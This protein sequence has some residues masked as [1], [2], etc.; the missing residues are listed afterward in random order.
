MNKR[1]I[2][3][4]LLSLICLNTKAQQIKGVVTDS[5]SVPIVNANISILNS[6]K[7]LGSITDSNGAYSI[8]V[9]ANVKLKIRFSYIGYQSV[10]TVV[11][12]KK[13]QTKTLNIVLKKDIISLQ[14]IEIKDKA[15]ERD[16]LTHIDKQW[17]QNAV[18]VDKQ[19]ENVIKSQE[20]VSSNNELSSQY[21]VRGGNFDENLVYV[22]DIEIFRPLLIRNGQQ[23]GLS[24][25]N[26]D[27]ISDIKFSSGGFD[28]KY[29]DKLSSVLDIRYSKP[30]EFKGSANMSL[31]GAAVHLEGLIGKRF[32]YTIG[33]RNKSSKYILNSLETSGD[34]N[35][36]FNDLQMYLT[37]SLNS[38]LELSFLGN[39]SDNKYNF[40][41]E[42]RQTQFG[43]IYTTMNL[44]IYFDGQ[45]QDRF[46]TGFGALM[47]NYSPKSDLNLKLI[48][49]GF[50][51]LEKETY[52]IQGQYWL[53]ETGGLGSDQEFDRG[54]GTYLEHARNR[55]HSQIYNIEHK[56][57]KDYSKGY[58]SWGVK[59]QREDIF[60]KLR[61]W[62]LVD[63]S[64]YTIPSCPDQIG[65]Y[66]P[67][68]PPNVQDYYKSKNSITTNR[69]TAYIQRQFVFEKKHGSYYFNIGIR[70]MYWD[71]N[72]EIMP[73]P[74]TSI[75]FRPNSKT[76]IVF[77]FA[78]GLYAQSPFYREMRD[79]SGNINYDIKSQKSW[80]FVLSEDWT[81]RML[82]RNFKFITTAY[83]KYLWDL[84]P[85]Q[86]DNVRIRYSGKNNAKGYATGMDFKLFGEFVQGIDSWITL[87]FLQTKQDIKGD[88][89]GYLPRPTDQLFNVSVSF[90]DYMP[91][92]PWMKVYLNFNYGSGYP[93]YKKDMDSYQRMPA[94]LRADMAFTFR[95]KDE[96]SSWAKGNF[97]TFFKRIWLNF[98]WLN[99]FN[100]N[101]VISYTNVQDFNGTIF[102]VPDYLT[103]SRLNVRLS[104]EF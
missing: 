15:T 11:I 63:S 71:F 14:E 74:R 84:I 34:Y 13:R 70:G 98:E 92:M 87:S 85:Y 78:T 37:Y 94:Y 3:I 102:S 21:S 58:L 61:E 82:D 29:G 91:N 99:V 45:E 64:D 9:F 53:T 24:F 1:Y 25:V 67:T 51:S 20:G 59:Y 19:I 89:H 62:R 43:N 95:L 31:M 76:D 16:G 18:G 42:D 12:L 101:N 44:K 56:G 35:S 93:Y 23:E 88:K 49:S 28:A 8:D 26:T 90:Q 41:P 30:T 104:I 48:F 75:S 60:D 97:M 32:T 2:I 47:L 83:Y 38:K 68:T 80:H 39:L 55:L 17:A 52:D 46:T 36:T 54:I 22:N 5:L 96:N 103:P 77:R 27:M 33:Y 81:F 40:T 57:Q 100:K 69:F 66:D 4:I 65:I 73:C 7:P 86:I 79:Y 10:D 50:N 6:E 72:D